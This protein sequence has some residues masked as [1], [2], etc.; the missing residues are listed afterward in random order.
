MA[1][2]ISPLGRQAAIAATFSGRT[3]LAQRR[4]YQED[5]QAAKQEQEQQVKRQFGLV[6]QRAELADP[7]KA[8]TLR[9]NE[10]KALT[11]EN[12]FDERMTAEERRFQLKMQ[13]D[14]EV[15]SL[16]E[17]QAEIAERKE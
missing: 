10:R 2:P 4:R 1:E 14:Q 7:L 6:N 12:Q 16:R 5:I 15:M 3:N 13:K 11:Q 17:R 9:L 8:R